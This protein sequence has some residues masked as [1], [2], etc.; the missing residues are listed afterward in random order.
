MVVVEN[1]CCCRVRTACL[2]FGSLLLVGAIYSIGNE[3]LSVVTETGEN[4][5]FTE[6]STYTIQE[7]HDVYIK[8]GII[9]T[10][11]QTAIFI[12]IDYYINC[13]N[14]FLSV[15]MVIVASFLIFGTHKAKSR[16]LAPSLVFLPIDT[17]VQVIF[18]FVLVA[19][20]GFLEPLVITF[21]MINISGIIINFFT[22]LCVFSHWQQ[23]KGQLVDQEEGPAMEKCTL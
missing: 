9:I 1:C 16:F 11:E 20:L 18:N 12:S 19:N 7:L 8:R 22:W 14:L 10:R 2:V 23:T 15:C 6:N 13:I 4:S 21:N 3:C 5:A 17:L